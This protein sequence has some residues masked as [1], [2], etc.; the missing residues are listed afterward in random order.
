MR[1]VVGV[2]ADVLVASL[3]E[4][5]TMAVYLPYWTDQRPMMTLVLRTGMD[6]A[7]SVGAIRR[8]VREVAPEVPEPRFRT[9]RQV[10]SGS[11]SG[12]NFSTLLVSAFGGITLLLA[13]L[14]VYGVVSYSVAQRR[15][16]MG[17][18]LALGARPGQV[19]GLVLRQGMLPVVFGVVAGLLGAAAG[20]RT[21]ESMLYQVGSLDPATFVAVP[22]VLLLV[23]LA[24]CYF[25]ARSTARVDPVIALR[26]D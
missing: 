12:R 20:A 26:C 25:P 17:I 11:V 21:L 8:I 19:R 14:G 3:E 23:A 7:S 24:A 18:R 22:A 9:M 1:R 16:E 6:P 15:N 10:V 4:D 2:V 13:C 5:T